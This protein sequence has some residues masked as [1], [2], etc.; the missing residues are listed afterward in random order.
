MAQ[1][2]AI[3][4][5]QEID[6]K[7]YKIEREL[8]ASEERKEYVKVKKF[9]EAAPEKL[10][11]L[12]MKAKSLRAEADE[13]VKQYERLEE[14][15][16]DF[17]NLDELVTGGAD[18]SFYRKKAQLK[19]DQLK[20][21]RADLNALTAA[22]KETDE[23]YQKL[24]KQVLSVEK[25]AVDIY[26]KYKELKAAKDAE[27][28]PYEEQLAVL[29]REISATLLEVY[30]TKRK[31]KIFPVVGQINGN[32]CPYCSMDLPIAARSKLSGGA[33]IE[34]ENHICSRILFE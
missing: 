29:E 31:E 13:L 2:Q 28:K 15:L 21:M 34:C 25:K 7:I 22:I 4:K 5:Y 11:A 23:E 27:K 19:I 24:K 17:D 18:I 33:W 3:L 8:S 1:L 30:K 9:L 26:K 10:D 20:K 16:K 32:R 6:A 12:E 14:T